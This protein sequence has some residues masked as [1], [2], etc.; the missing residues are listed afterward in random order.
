MIAT[1]NMYQLRNACSAN[2]II[3]SSSDILILLAQRS[4]IVN[5]LTDIIRLSIATS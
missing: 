1:V 3:T 4:R 5:D 2:L